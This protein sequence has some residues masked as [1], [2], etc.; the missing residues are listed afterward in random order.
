MLST[1][2]TGSGVC[3]WASV[4]KLSRLS[5]LQPQ[6]VRTHTNVLRV[7]FTGQAGRRAGQQIFKRY[8]ANEAKATVRGIPVESTRVGLT[9]TH[10]FN[11]HIK[12]V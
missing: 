8:S 4:T 7:S 9:G 12:F 5:K 11:V 3:S 6:L 10:I 1:L 2:R